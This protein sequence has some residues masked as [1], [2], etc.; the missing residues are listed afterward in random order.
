MTSEKNITTIINYLQV[1]NVQSVAFDMFGIHLIQLCGNRIKVFNEDALMKLLRKL[2]MNIT[3]TNNQGQ[4]ILK[5]NQ[6]IKQLYIKEMID[7]QY[8]SE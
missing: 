1:N 5:E 7:A 4:L 6:Q 2:F 3:T 8:I